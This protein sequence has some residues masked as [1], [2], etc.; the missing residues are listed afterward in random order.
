MNRHVNNISGRLSLRPP[1]QNSLVILDRVCEILF[2]QKDLDSSACAKG[3]R[4]AQLTSLFLPL[5]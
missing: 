4:T 3:D 5:T 1:Q 2:N